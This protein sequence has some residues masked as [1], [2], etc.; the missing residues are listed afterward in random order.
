MGGGSSEFSFSVPPQATK[1]TFVMIS[2]PQ[3]GLTVYLVIGMTGGSG[4][5]VARKRH[6]SFRAWGVRGLKQVQHRNYLQA[7]VP[8]VLVAN[9]TVV[10]TTDMFIFLF[11]LVE[12]MN[13]R[14]QVG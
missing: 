14:T 3:C 10:M 6:S 4:F 5:L 11:L 9:I 12:Y 2:V 1:R 8:K 7:L 13:F